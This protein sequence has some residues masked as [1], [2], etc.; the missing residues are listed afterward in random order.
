[1]GWKM[2]IHKGP[3]GLWFVLRS[4]RLVEHGERICK[5]WNLER[6]DVEYVF[7]LIKLWH[8]KMQ[9]RFYNKLLNAYNY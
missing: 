6:Q 1:M 7:Q 5:F 8:N 4:R 3:I 2:K 9:R